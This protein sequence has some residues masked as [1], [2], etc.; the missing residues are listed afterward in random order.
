MSQNEGFLSPDL[1]TSI[2]NI[3]R[4]FSPWFGVAESFVKLGMRVLPEVKAGQTN[5]QQLIAAALYGRAL[6]SFQA[7]Y[8]LTERGLLADARTVV[9]AAAETTIVLSAVVKDAKVCDLL[10][11]RH[12]WHHRKLR[13]A[14]LNDPQAVAEMTPEQIDAVKATLAEA[15]ASHPAAKQLKA[16][17]IE[18]ATLAQQSGVTALYN[19]VYR[20]TSGDAA[21]TSID[22]L[23]RHINADEDGNIQGLK[24]G[25][26]VRDLPATLSDG[27]SVIGHAIHA[28]LDLFQLE[29]FND[30]L[31]R[32]TASW[33]ALVV[34][35]E[36]KPELN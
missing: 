20:T 31:S 23:D 18:I 9:R 24:F 25:P 32:C 34:A 15:D 29:Q 19:A 1:A 36:S 14:W 33:K 11:D 28:V 30:D 2:A 35:G 17:P 16:D 10:V 22:A 7:A 3:R 5:N 21:H 27:I 8:V 12:F 13:N 4:D 6:T 26:D